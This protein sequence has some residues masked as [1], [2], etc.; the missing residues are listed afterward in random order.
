MT[1]PAVDPTRCPL[2]GDDNACGVARGAGTC[3]CFSTP[4][5]EAVLARVP[6]ALQGVACVCERCASGRRSPAETQALIE[7]PTRGR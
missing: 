6:P 3:W 7:R 1:V 4:V 5:P 2:C